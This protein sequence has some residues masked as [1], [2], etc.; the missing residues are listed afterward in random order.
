MWHWFADDALFIRDRIHPSSHPPPSNCA[1]A[2]QSATTKACHSGEVHALSPSATSIFPPHL[3]SPV[4]LPGSSN[5]DT[6]TSGWSS[7]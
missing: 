6:A 4:A 7:L 2:E 5:S 1:E 3:N